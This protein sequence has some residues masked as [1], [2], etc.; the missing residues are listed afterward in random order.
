MDVAAPRAP[1][2]GGGGGG[3]RSTPPPQ[4]LGLLVNCYPK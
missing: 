3:C 1:G 2:G 4:K